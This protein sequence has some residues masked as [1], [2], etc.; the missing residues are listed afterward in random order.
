MIAR[1]GADASVNDVE[2]EATLVIAREG[3]VASV[4]DVVH[5]RFRCVL[6]VN[7]NLKHH[8]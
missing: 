7:E 2:A 4:N 8:L 1:E 6:P 5:G 3:A